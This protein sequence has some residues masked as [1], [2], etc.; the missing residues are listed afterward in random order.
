MMTNQN[1]DFIPEL[2]SRVVG[3]DW[4]LSRNSQPVSDDDILKELNEVANGE[5]TFS[6][7]PKLMN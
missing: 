7:K 3:L 1:Q 2:G 6:V 4:Y 5:K